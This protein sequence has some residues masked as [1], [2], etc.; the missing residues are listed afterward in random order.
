MDLHVRI[1]H[2]NTSTVTSELIIFTVTSEPI[3][4]KVTSELIIFTVFFLQTM[5][6]INKVS[7]FV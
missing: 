2:L 4:F 1:L 6:S 3:I 5:H 7:R